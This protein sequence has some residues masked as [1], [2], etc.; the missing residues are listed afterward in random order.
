LVFV[1]GTLTVTPA[2]LTVVANSYSRPINS[3]N[4]AFG[5]TIS[6]FVNGDTQWSATTG[7]PACCTTTATAS[8]PA[9]DY[10]ITI[11]P[12]NLAAK[13]GNYTFTFVNG[14]LIV[15]NPKN[16][17]DSH[18]DGHGNY[19]PN[20]QWDASHWPDNSSYGYYWGKGGKGPSINICR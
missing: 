12:G 5:Y 6:G 13:N 1:N 3:P 8:S 4:P 18:C 20:P 2:T 9:G 16:P 14:V 10:T 15:Y 17:G 11:G 19:Q 7:A